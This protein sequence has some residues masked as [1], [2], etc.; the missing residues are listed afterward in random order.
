MDVATLLGDLRLAAPE[1][2]LAGGAMAL[3]MVGVLFG[4]RLQIIASV[5]LA[6]AVTLGAGLALASSSAFGEDGGANLFAFAATGLAS[7]IAFL[8]ARPA[9][10]I[11]GA[12][13][14]FLVAAGALAIIPAPE[15]V[16][17]AFNGAFA[18]DG[19]SSFAK[20]V[21]ALSG[22]ASLV[23]AAR[24]LVG[25]RLA[26]FEFSVLVMLAVM[27][28]LMMVSAR[29][30]IALY[31]GLE[32]QSLALYVL[33]AFNRD[34]VRASE[35]GLKYFVLGALSSGLLLYGSSLIY[36][37]TGST[38]FVEIAAA[39]GEEPSIGLLFGLVFLMCGVAFKIS[40]APFHMWTPDVYEGAP[41]PVTALFSAAPKMAAMVL[42]ARAL[43]EPFPE[44]AADW[45][46]IIM[47]LAALSMAVGSFGALAQRNIKRLM[48]YS[49]IGNMGFALVAL[50]AGTREGLEGLL[51][52]MTIYL[53]STT[54][55]FACIL[56]MRRREGMVEK[57]EDLAGLS[58]SHPGL[59]VAM[60]M[61]LFSVAGIPP[62]AGFFG[63]F[64][65]FLPAA[66]AGLWPLVIFAVVMSVVSAFYY[67]RLIR[68][69]WFDQP[70]QPLVA[71][72]RE[73]GFIAG[74]SAFAMFPLFI[75]PFVA[76]PG[77]ALVE[78]AAGALF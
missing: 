45:R 20:V 72:P 50:S 25:E 68:L 28:M 44:I 4:E 38:Q 7:L 37:F 8:G 36:G 78:T 77:R 35:A 65:A 9:G 33:A 13:A 11:N 59:A 18:V 21:I 34:S 62:L 51:I 64:F 47:A 32:M 10:P 3:L 31:I 67:L 23:M 54:G 6:L 43:Y 42:F 26:K 58:R 46:Q 57:I 14:S 69:M 2:T 1:L 74:L 30:L 70:A 41:T 22:A 75:A 61:L 29:D 27:G 48:A 56:A 5:A 66:E 53:V 76:A 12:A 17:A 39:V 40:A 63:K 16:E 73:L 71:A 60:T 55:I 15:G 52:Y 19:L 24:Y 49:S